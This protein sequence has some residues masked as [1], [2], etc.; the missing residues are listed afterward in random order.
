MTWERYG[1]YTRQK[2]YRIIILIHDVNIFHQSR[3][4]F[5]FFFDVGTSENLV[6]EFFFSS[7]R[8]CSRTCVGFPEDRATISSALYIACY[9]FQKDLYGKKD[10]LTMLH[11]F[12]ERKHTYIVNT[13]FSRWTRQKFIS[14][15]AWLRAN[16]NRLV[17]PLNSDLEVIL[18]S[19]KTE[20]F[21]LL[22]RVYI[23]FRSADMFNCERFLKKFENF[24]K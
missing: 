18:D 1:N 12:Q 20:N 11:L 14:F 9:E 13:Y 16:N 2:A 8:V 24:D 7:K 10:F 3:L 22:H 5:Q 6:F 23:T 19:E 17:D 4:R 21:T 15:D